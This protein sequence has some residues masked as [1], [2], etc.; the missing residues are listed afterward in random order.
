[1]GLS[2]G[3]KRTIMSHLSLYHSHGLFLSSFQGDLQH[4]P[5]ATRGSVTGFSER[6]ARRM[7]KYLRESASRY[8]TLATLTYPGGDSWHRAKDH[9]RALWER[10]RRA[11]DAVSI[12]TRDPEGDQPFSAVWFLEF[13][14]RGVPHFH[15]F[16]THRI[17][18]RWLARA[19]FDIVGSGR[20]EHLAA[21]TRIESI[22]TGR[23]GCIGY[24]R[25]YATKREQKELPPLLENQGFGRWWGVTGCRETVLAVGG[26]PQSVR[27]AKS[28]RK[29]LASARR[30]LKAAARA[31]KA[32][33]R[34]H[35][36]VTVIVLK[37]EELQRWA[38]AFIAE[39]NEEVSRC[40]R[41]ARGDPTGV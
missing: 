30:T 13:Q 29:L 39:L 22:R 34:R 6:S 19:W 23:R 17:D 33:V 10:L 5:I 20:A 37:T 35:E 16:C 1:M 36:W 14:R 18:R 38:D 21:G 41:N 11:G 9:L 8:R 40:L 15:F 2:V 12:D 26:V 7:C 28:V 27:G 24:A 4:A 31:G 25:K 32:T 3:H